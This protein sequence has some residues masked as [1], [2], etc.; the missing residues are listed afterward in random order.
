MRFRG[1]ETTAS[2]NHRSFRTRF[3][4]TKRVDD[5][6]LLP[7]ERRVSVRTICYDVVVMSNACTT[8]CLPLSQRVYRNIIVNVIVYLRLRFLSS[9]LDG[10]E[11]IENGF[12]AAYF[13]GRRV[14]RA[15]MTTSVPCDRRWPP[16]FTRSAAIVFD[17]IATD[18][19]RFPRFTILGP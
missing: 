17:S 19:R 9:R 4:A 13:P 18:G 11:L 7:A 6:H 16:K 8:H 10:I 5:R 1:R 3:A 15:Q 2:D 14:I 12:G